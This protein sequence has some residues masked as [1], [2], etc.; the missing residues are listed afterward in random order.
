MDDIRAVAKELRRIAD[1]NERIAKALEK[2]NRAEGISP[3][4]SVAGKLPD[5]ETTVEALTKAIMESAKART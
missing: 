4:I 3:N 1:A 2:R 5:T